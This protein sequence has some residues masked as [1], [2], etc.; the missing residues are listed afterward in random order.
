RHLEPD[1]DAAAAVGQRV[2]RRVRRARR[3]RERDLLDVG[4]ARARA[5][6][7]AEV[8]RRERELDLDRSR[9]DPVGAEVREDARDGLAERSPPALL[10]DRGLLV[11]TAEPDRELPG[12]A[13]RDPVDEDAVDGLPVLDL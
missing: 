2:A 12:E 6:A 5:G 13:V 11:R 9:R 4:G 10:G 7:L 1:R 8:G 3:A